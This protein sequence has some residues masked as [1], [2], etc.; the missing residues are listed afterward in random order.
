MPAGA[1]YVDLATPEPEYEAEEASG[2]DGAVIALLFAVSL[3]YVL[4]ARPIDA[5]A[6]QKA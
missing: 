6:S 1:G 2:P 3:L 5:L 4:G